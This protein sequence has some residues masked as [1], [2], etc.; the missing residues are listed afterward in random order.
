MLTD[1]VEGLGFNLAN[2]FTSNT[3]DF[4]DF[5]KRVGYPIGKTEAHFKNL[6]FALG[7]VADDFIEVVFQNPAAGDGFRRDGIFIGNEVRQYRITLII[8]DR[9]LEWHGVLRDLNNMSD[10]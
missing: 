2:A 1:F 3:E 8:P 9:S 7:K 5:F 10:F 4:A 6:L